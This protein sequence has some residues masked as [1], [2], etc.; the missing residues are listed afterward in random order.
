[1][2]K[3]IKN[4]KGDI[5]ITILVIGILAI[6]GLTVFSFYLSIGKAQEGLGSF[7][8]VEKTVINMEKMSLYRNLGLDEGEIGKLFEVK[9]EADGQRRYIGVEREGIAVKYYLP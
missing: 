7:D 9:S 4:K 6:C 1:M 2:K 5:P 3:L 8:A